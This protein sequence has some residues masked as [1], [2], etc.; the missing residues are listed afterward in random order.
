MAYST[1]QEVRLA[2]V[3]TGDGGQPTAPTH[4]AA[5][6]TD[7]QL[8]DAI[9]EGDSI[10]DGYLGGRYT[11]P[12]E[13]VSGTVPAPLA[14]WSRSLAAYFATL[15][16]RRGQDFADTDPVARRYNAVMLAL[17]DV[18]AGK[19]LLPLPQPGGGTGTALSA[20]GQAV[21]PY[22]GDLWTPEDFDLTP[23]WPDRLNGRW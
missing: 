6:L 12:V 1:P 20:V 8:A 14:M 10:I 16:Y 4:T 7:E 11:T 22:I 15:A 23:D 9:A 5:D 19:L 17:K 3:P 2:L 13:P 18:E 21:N